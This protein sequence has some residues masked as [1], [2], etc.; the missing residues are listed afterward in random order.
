M[1][2]T[3]TALAL[4]YAGSRCP[5]VCTTPG[6]CSFGCGRRWQFATSN[7]GGHAVCAVT[8]RFMLVLRE[9]MDATPGLGP[10]QIAHAL[11]TNR[12][13]VRAWYEYACQLN[14]DQV[15][16]IHRPRVVAA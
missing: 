2:D 3:L 1:T 15:T 11:G 8:T 6:L 7:L 10:Q 9:T 5:I 14:P 13:I 4:A 12:R 16:R